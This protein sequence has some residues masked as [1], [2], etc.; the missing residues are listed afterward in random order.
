MNEDREQIKSLRR[1]IIEQLE[2][3]GKDDK[4]AEL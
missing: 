1:Q 2:M 4:V 3:L